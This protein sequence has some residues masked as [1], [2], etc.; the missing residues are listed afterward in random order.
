MFSLSALIRSLALLCS[1]TQ[2]LGTPIDTQADITN[3]FSSVESDLKSL[4][5]Q[6]AP[7]TIED[8][9]ST[10]QSIL[11]GKNLTL[12]DTATQLISAG[13]SSLT[14]DG[15]VSYI[16]GLESGLASSSN[17]NSREPSVA[18]F[19]SASIGD[20]PYSFSEDELRSA[21]YIPG[22]F[23]YG[24]SGAPQPILLVGGTGNPGYVTFVGTYIK[25]LQNEETSFGDPVWLNIPGYELDD[26]QK[27]A[28]FVAYAI[29]YLS[30]ICGNRLI[31]VMGY[32]QGNLDAQWAYKYWPSTRAHVTDHVAFS[33]GYRGTKLTQILSWVPQPPAWLQ[34]LYDSDF[35]LAMRANGGD[36]SYV[37]TTIIYSLT[38]EVVQPQFGPG[39]SSPLK[40]AHGAG[41]T[42]VRVQDACSGQVAGG[43]YTHEGIPYNPLAYA[44]ARDAVLN[45]GTGQL[46]R[47][48]LHAICGNYLAPTLTLE[49]FLVTENNVVVAA[50]LTLLYEGKSTTEPVIADYAK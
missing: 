22:N 26:L 20:A 43:F 44:L 5:V 31:A 38:D 7:S 8:A 41:V 3:Y 33:P 42:N 27:N 17:V 1:I 39:A 30:G 9:F 18:V 16:D 49:D 48:D 45:D 47:L 35:V 25:L 2:V 13:L 11:E 46:S 40:D 36:S 24:V 28:E 4:T 12:F 32:S 14:W 37:P 23:T 34:A 19:P 21:L 50:V 29:N 15:V 6:T 10:L